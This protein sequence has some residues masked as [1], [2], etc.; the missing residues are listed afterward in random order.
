MGRELK[1]VPLDFDWPQRQTWEG[2]LNPYYKLAKRCTACGATGYAPQAKLFKEQ[3][4]GNADF[5]PVAYGAT[6]LTVD[7]P[8]VQEFARRNVERHPEYYGADSSAVQ[9]EARRLFELWRGQ[10]SHH[11]IQ[12]DVDALV[13]ADRLYDFTRVPRTEV[14][15]SALRKSGGYWLPASNGYTPTAGEVNSW[16]LCG[17]GHDA[18]NAWVCVRARCEREGVPVECEVCH[19]EQ[20]LWPSEAAK[21]LCESWQV[22]EPPTGDGFQLW[23][24]T[25][26][27]SPASPVFE[28]LEAL[29]EWCADNAT[30]FGSAKATAAEWLS[31]L[32][33]GFVCHTDG[34]NIFM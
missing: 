10:W 2:Y 13:A 24:T 32:G 11:L 26:E 16:S 17:M 25:S 8:A 27:G 14:Q 33:A 7:H 23:E 30:T 29:C 3:W 12:A 34:R 18:V 1:R 31:M 21:Q 22:V 19:G 5:D 28:T 20:D 15:R 4:Y 9:R 6:P